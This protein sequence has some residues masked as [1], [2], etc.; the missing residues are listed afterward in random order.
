MQEPHIKEMIKAMLI[1]LWFILNYEGKLSSWQ[2]I[3]SSEIEIKNLYKSLK[4]HEPSN[5]ANK[6]G[7]KLINVRVFG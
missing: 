7:G 1:S 3:S 5:G 4:G 2:T 6:Y